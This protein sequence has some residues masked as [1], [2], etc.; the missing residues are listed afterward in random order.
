MTKLVACQMVSCPD[1]E[2]NL[3]Q[4]ELMLEKQVPG[5]VVVL[6]ECFAC[7][8]D[9]DKALLQK[10][11]PLRDGPIQK[12]LSELAH[13]F[14]LWIFAGTVPIKSSDPNKFT[15][16]CLVFND[17]GECV[18]EYQKIHLFDVQVQDS[19]KHYQ[20]SRHT[21]AGDKI[22]V[23]DSPVGRIGVAVCYDIRFPGL[24]QAMG[25][26]DALVLPSAFTETTGRAHWHT[27]LQARAV[28]NQCYVVA[29]NQGGK[30]QNGR[31][32]FGH[33]CI[34]SPWGE[35][36]DELTK[37]QGTVCADFDIDLLKR[38]RTNMPIHQHNQFRSS[39]V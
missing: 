4:V 10:S 2:Q 15:A 12:R 5:S 9:S 27:L 37:N 3:R 26:V 35:I 39:L 33:S 28:E 19:T 14:K 8:G 16:S 36:I 11:E 7:F 1:P 18:G 30:H 17:L 22:L 25:Q 20:E 13:R 23:V 29:A 34:I 6:P 31:E 38:I 21:L 24:F 32:T